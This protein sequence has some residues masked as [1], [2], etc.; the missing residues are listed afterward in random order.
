MLIQGLTYVFG[1]SLK[2]KDIIKKIKNYMK[3]KSISKQGKSLNHIPDS[4]DDHNIRLLVALVNSNEFD[5][6]LN[7]NDNEE[8]VSSC[9][10]WLKQV[11]YMLQLKQTYNEEVGR[12]TKSIQEAENSITR[13]ELSVCSL[14]TIL[15]V[16]RKKSRKRRKTFTTWRR[17]LQIFTRLPAI[18]GK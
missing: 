9:A 8:Y 2:G 15:L 17:D 4:V 14:K 12:N 10:T 6:L 7:V 11:S 5:K 18:V 16:D 3:V 13:E 1:K